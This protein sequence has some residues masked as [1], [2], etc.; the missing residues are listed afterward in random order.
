MKKAY[1]YPISS[2]QGKVTFSAYI[3]NFMNYCSGEFL[4]L[5]RTKP[6][7]KGIFDILSY[8]RNIQFVFLNWIEDLPD[9]RG[10]LVQTI[11]FVLLVYFLKARKVKIVWTMHNKESHYKSN[12]WLKKKLF[13]FILRKSDY[14][15]THARDGIVCFNQYKVNHAEKIRYFPHPLNKEFLPLKT[16]PYHDILIWGSII[17]YKGVD[18][19]LSF[20]HERKLQ[21]KYRICIAGKVKP[22]D[23]IEKIKSYCN[24]NI[25]L[26]NRYIPAKDLEGLMCN[27]K[28][29]LF[30]YLDDSVLSSG[31][32][33]DTLS[34]GMEILGPHAGA[35][36]D[37]QEEGLI[38]TFSGY[39]E[40]MGLLDKNLMEWPQNNRIAIEKFI[41]QY[42]WNQ[43][44]IEMADWIKDDPAWHA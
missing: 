36:K 42:N 17:P 4:F 40:L 28:I 11:F 32:L 12:L 10:G 33:M 21:D 31:A 14:I 27:S 29:I 6:S 1:L 7:G 34:Y 39:D 16:D 24:N 15:L 13:G 41:E 19:F 9:K 18:K 22:D 26:E 23:Y 3:E 38:H 25:V 37:A 44:A 20:L 35:F 5:N 8:M 2:S 43:F 30:T